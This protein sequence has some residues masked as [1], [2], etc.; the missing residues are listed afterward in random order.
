MLTLRQIEVVR[1]IMV[2]GTIA[3]AAKLLNVSAPGISRLMKYT[4]DSLGV[5]LFD[6]R[7]GRYVPT[8]EART[9]FDLLDT[10]YRKVEDLQD[11]IGALGK[12]AGQELCFA[13]VPSIAN[14]MMPRAVERLRR[15]FPD[16]GLDINILKIEEA[17]DYLLL[18]R[19]EV[20]AI[21][22]RFEHSVIDFMPLATGRLLCI[23]P[24]GDPL[25][26]RR[27]IA[28]EEM[29]GHSLIGIDP[30]DPYG[31]IMAGIFRQRGLGYSMNIKARFGTTVCSL[32]AAGLGI[33]IIDEFTVAHG[34]PGVATL[35]IEAET[36]FHTYA[37][38]RNDRPLSVYAEAFVDL[39]R[40][41]MEAGSQRG[42]SA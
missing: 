24:A 13:S 33:A 29:A 14:V 5:R 10:V 8:P 3:G 32:V 15:R 35:E 26:G 7:N 42:G 34:V 30:N 27:S 28:P 38:H 18:G 9:I 37:A 2:S 11:A 6:R 31:S 12:G 23:V 40:N 19:G 21:S 1:A 20:V 22:S 25:A 4:E 41:E 36:T 39:L 17:I 16:L